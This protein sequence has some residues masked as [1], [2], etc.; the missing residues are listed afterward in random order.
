MKFIFYFTFLLLHS[1]IFSQDID[2]ALRLFQEGKYQDAI[3]ECDK[4]IIESHRIGE[5]FY[6]RGYCKVHTEDF[7]GAISDFNKAI[8]VKHLSKYYSIRGFCYNK[9]GM[10]KDAISDYSV[11]LKEFPDDLDYLDSRGVCYMKLN[12]DKLALNDFDRILILDSKNN[13]ALFWK[14]LI[15]VNNRIIDEGCKYLL[16]AKQLGYVDKFN[17]L[18]TYCP[19]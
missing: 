14:G 3:F 8:E 17:T 4:I 6:I 1:K 19:K 5:V 11:C 15:L 7:Y 12:E 9:L 13:N 18:D 10:C 2:Y 16:K